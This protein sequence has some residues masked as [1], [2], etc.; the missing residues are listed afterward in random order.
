MRDDGG[1]IWVQPIAVLVFSI[2]FVWFFFSETSDHNYLQYPEYKQVI[3]SDPDLKEYNEQKVKP[4]FNKIEADGVIMRYEMVQ[5]S[6]AMDL[7]RYKQKQDQN[8]IE[9]LENER[10]VKLIK[11]SFGK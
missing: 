3:L 10:R 2:G 5:I 4:D 1:F 9:K 11:E 7:I 6:D 8:E